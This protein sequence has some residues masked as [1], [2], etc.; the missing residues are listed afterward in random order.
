MILN[1]PTVAIDCFP[2]SAARYR[3]GHAIVAVDVIRATTLAVTAVAAGRRC[4]VAASLE[5]AVAL[6]DRL[7]NALLA[8]ELGGT[9]PSGF[10]MNNS[11]SDL[12]ARDDVERPL[13]MLSSSGTELMLAASRSTRDAYV[14]CFRNLTAVARHLIGRHQ[15]VALIGAGSRG[16][17]REED[18]MGCSWIADM[19]LRAGY[20]AEDSATAEVIERWRGVPAT[21]IEAANSVAYLRRTD[22]LRDFAFTLDHID[23]LD[24]VCSIEGNEIRRVL[25]RGP[26]D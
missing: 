4:L 16:E 8:G 26:R 21:A 20:R 18:Q 17:F 22:Q 6:R 2:S 5:D 12:V 9:T 10:D 15:R 1:D 13:V 25:A 24:L 14:A 3:G 7:G 19:L 23:D 11:P